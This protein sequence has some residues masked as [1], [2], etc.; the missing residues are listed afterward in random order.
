MSPF[1]TTSNW[2]ISSSIATISS[3]SGT[4]TSFS[5][6]SAPSLPALAQQHL[7]N[8]PLLAES[9]IGKIIEHCPVV[10]TFCL[11]KP[12][13]QFSNLGW[14]CFVRISFFQWTATF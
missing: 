14:N 13:F 1:Y 7:R 4:V 8:P 2:T 10:V 6:A 3:S 9:T 12:E 5:T 11:F